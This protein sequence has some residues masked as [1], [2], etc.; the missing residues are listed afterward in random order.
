MHPPTHPAAAL[1]PDREHVLRGVVAGR[2]DDPAV[3]MGY[4]V[5]LRDC[6]VVRERSE[7]SRVPV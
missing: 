6:R 3:S 7:R 5:V 1:P 2:H 4:V